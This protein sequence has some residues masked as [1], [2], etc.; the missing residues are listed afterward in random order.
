MSAA[1]DVASQPLKGV[2]LTTTS[3]SS[4]QQLKSEQQVKE[5]SG[6]VDELTRQL[7]DLAALNQSLLT[8][9]KS[10]TTLVAQNNEALTAI[11]QRV[12]TLSKQVNSSFYNGMSVGAIPVI[13]QA[14]WLW[15]T[16]RDNLCGGKK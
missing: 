11:N 9:N 6:K 14:V 4:D 1:K 8:Q 10:L 5:L 13:G 15:F 2:I 12:D 7:K 3:T 16:I